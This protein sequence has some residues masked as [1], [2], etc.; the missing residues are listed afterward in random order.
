MITPTNS[1]KLL[2]EIGPSFQYI[3]QK[4][5]KRLLYFY[6][7]IVLLSTTILVLTNKSAWQAFALGLIVPGGSFLMHASISNLEGIIHI[8]SAASLFAIFIASIVVWFGSGNFIAPPSV[9]LLSA[10]GG[11]IWHSNKLPMADIC[12]QV[13]PSFIIL[14]GFIALL[15]CF[16]LIASLPRHFQTKLRQ[17]TN[18]YLTHCQDTPKDHNH[19]SEKYELSPKTLKLMRFVL[20]RALQPIDEFNGFEWYDQFQTAAIRYQLH[21]MGYALSMLQHTHLSAFGGYLNQAQENLIRKQQNPK[22]WRYWQLENSWG[23]L[24]KNPDPIA[25]D[26]IMYSGFGATQILMYQSCAGK[27]SIQPLTLRHHRFW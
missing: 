14:Y 21:F 6:L 22:V 27:K 9:W 24:N 25:K 12:G 7:A 2:P 23:N 26:N 15:T 10:I 11:A 20:D 16:L 19:I 13:I 18:A 3:S 8:A 1:V 17:R 5:K 4:K